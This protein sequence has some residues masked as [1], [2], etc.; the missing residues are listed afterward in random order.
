MHG[1]QT[2]FGDEMMRDDSQLMKAMIWLQ[3]TLADGPV[4]AVKVKSAAAKA[5]FSQMTVRRAGE[6]LAVVAQKQGFGKTGRWYWRLPKGAQDEG[7]RGSNI[8]GIDDGLASLALDLELEMDDEAR[9]LGET[10]EAEL[11]DL[12]LTEEDMTFLD[13]QARR[14]R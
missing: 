5:G 10:L 3:E 6:R 9:R 8:D 12:R 1:R 4:S 11:S 7:L 2:T 14:R 13:E